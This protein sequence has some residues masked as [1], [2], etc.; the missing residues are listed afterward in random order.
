MSYQL[1]PMRMILLFIILLFYY[2]FFGP[3]S[4]RLTGSWLDA[5]NETWVNCLQGKYLTHFLAPG[6]YFLKSPTNNQ[7]WQRCR[8]P[9]FTDCETVSGFLQGKQYK[10][11]SKIKKQNEHLI[12]QYHSQVFITKALRF[13][14]RY[15]LT[16]IPFLFYNNSSSCN[17]NFTKSLHQSLK[18]VSTYKIS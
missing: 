14:K 16:C 9:M 8:E 3:Y 6:P 10:D 7:C 12:Q 4:E 15:I 13:W 2:L 17:R 11:V 1:I 18:Y 5:G